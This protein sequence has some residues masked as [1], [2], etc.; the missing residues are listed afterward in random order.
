MT[1]S[2]AKKESGY[3]KAKLEDIEKRLD[4]IE[5]KVDSLFWK[6]MTV[7]STVAI[8]IFIVTKNITN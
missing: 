5:N 8:I 2:N 7:S 1:I 4:R 3:L 6:T